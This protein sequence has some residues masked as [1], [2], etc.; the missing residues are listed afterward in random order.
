MKAIDPG[1]MQPEIHLAYNPSVDGPPPAEAL[2]RVAVRPWGSETETDWEWVTDPNT[3]VS[4]YECETYTVSVQ[5]NWGGQVLDAGTQLAV[6]SIEFYGNSH[7]YHARILTGPAHNCHILLVVP[8]GDTKMPT[9]AQ[10]QA[11]D[12]VYVKPAESGAT[13]TTKQ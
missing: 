10:L 8:T 7:V 12:G 3:G 5:A 2:E 1:T 6:S 11:E 13:A 9:F 4:T